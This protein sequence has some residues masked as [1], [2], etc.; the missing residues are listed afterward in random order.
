[1]GSIFIGL[2]VAAAVCYFYFRWI[3]DKHR[4]EVESILPR[5]GN[6]FS[7]KDDLHNTL[8]TGLYH[9]FKKEEGKTEDTPW[10]FERFVARV[11]ETN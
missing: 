4:K 6:L 5:V 7:V 10:D 3:Q 11:M 1:M 8:L 2:I 9:R